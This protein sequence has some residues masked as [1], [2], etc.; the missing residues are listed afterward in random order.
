MTVV[1]LMVMVMVML[2]VMAVIVIVAV[3]LLMAHSA[4]DARKTLLQHLN[5]KDPGAPAT[6]SPIQPRRPQAARGFTSSGH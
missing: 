3:G 1:V 4:Q 2:M 5:H 6:C